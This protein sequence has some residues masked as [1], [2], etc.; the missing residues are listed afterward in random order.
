MLLM[1]GIK[2]V[3]L[4]LLFLQW[5]SLRSWDCPLYSK[6]T[7]TFY[8]LLL[9]TFFYLKGSTTT[10]YFLDP[11]LVMSK[12]ETKT[13]TPLVSLLNWHSLICSL[14]LGLGGYSLVFVLVLLQDSCQSC[15]FKGLL[16]EALPT[17]QI[18]K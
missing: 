12:C 17:L 7:S 10:H 2:T 9:T 1:L 15:S 13:K 14:G 8:V 18:F 5:G 3:A 4:N 11:T 16:L 6:Y